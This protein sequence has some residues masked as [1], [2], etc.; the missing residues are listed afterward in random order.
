MRICSNR[1]NLCVLTCAMSELVAQLEAK[2]QI[3]LTFPTVDLIYC[4]MPFEQNNKNTSGPSAVGEM[5]R[6]GFSFFSGMAQVALS[7]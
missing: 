1:D 5:M 3:F 2:L 4:K 6:V 7:V